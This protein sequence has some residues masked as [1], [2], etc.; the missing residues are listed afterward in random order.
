MDDR[1]GERHAQRHRDYGFAVRLAV[2]II[3]ALTVESAGGWPPRAGSHRV[4][5]RR[6][7][8]N[9]RRLPGERLLRAGRI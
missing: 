1:F 6:T 9:L 5:P 8:P 7:S 4:H 2:T 3:A